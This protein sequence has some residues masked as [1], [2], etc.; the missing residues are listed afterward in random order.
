MVVKP[1][2][3]LVPHVAV[4]LMLLRGKYY[5]LSHPMSAHIIQGLFEG[6][7]RQSHLSPQEI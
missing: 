6:Y 1:I 3:T 5:L 2:S 7:T 4:M